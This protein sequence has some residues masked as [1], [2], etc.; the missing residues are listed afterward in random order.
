M[1]SRYSAKLSVFRRLTLDLADLTTC[2]KRKVGCVIVSED[3]MEVLG[4]GFNGQAIGEGDCPGGDPCGC[5]HAEANALIKM[6]YPSPKAI[7][8]LSCPPCL[9]CAG[10][11]INKQC[12]E[13]LLLVG[14]ETAS[15]AGVHRLHRSGIN[16]YEYLSDGSIFIADPTNKDR[17]RIH[18]L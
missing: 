3:F 2:A 13:K 17:H 16:C 6:R 1:D 15:Y 14:E 12:I 5:L 4:I 9:A 8:F 7:M 11:I 10:L 18:R